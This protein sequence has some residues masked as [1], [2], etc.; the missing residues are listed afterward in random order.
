MPQRIATVGALKVTYPYLEVNFLHT[1]KN[2]TDIAYKFTVPASPL[3]QFQL[4]QCH[5]GQ[6][7]KEIISCTVYNSAL[8]Q[9][10]M[11]TPHT[12]QGSQTRVFY[13]LVHNMNLQHCKHYQI[14]ARRHYIKPHIPVKKHSTRL[15]AVQKKNIL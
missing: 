15:P 3:V 13:R 4:P 2:L 12:A 9:L 7:V 11:Q 8:F 14:M 1:K 6:C 10:H 5:N